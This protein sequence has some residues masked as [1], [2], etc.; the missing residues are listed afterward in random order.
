MELNVAGTNIGERMPGR[1]LVGDELRD[2]LRLYYGR[3]LTRTE[4][5]ERKAC[6]ADDTRSRHAGILRLIPDE[7]KQRNYGCGCS[8]PQD[9]LQGLRVLDLGSGAGFD[10]FVVSYLVG[11]SGHVYGIDMTDEQLAVA[12]RNV[13]PVM[14]AYEYRRPNVEFH[15]SY[16]ETADPIVD[17]SIDLVISDCTINLSPLK[18]SVFETILRV[19]KPGGEFYI[20]DIVAD[21]RVPAKLAEDKKLVAEC[22]GGALY[23]HDLTD[24]MK[25]CGF[26]DPRVVTTQLVE[27]NVSGCSIRFYSVTMRGFKFTQPLDRRCEDYGQVA[28]YSGNCSQQPAKFVLDNQHTF[29]AGRPVPV[30]RNTARMLSETR[31]AR[32]FEVTPPR[33]HLGI[34]ACGPATRHEDDPASRCC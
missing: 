3:V 14:Q 24:I 2:Y 25:D 22:L 30:C 21:R 27:E 6:C 16:I 1:G 9:D 11:E 4:D 31:L 5:L 28:T 12:R 32:Y 17:G 19:L 13:D 26:G 33:Q 29:E 34:F 8:I 10:A 20:S 7:V 18:N 15:K 23:A